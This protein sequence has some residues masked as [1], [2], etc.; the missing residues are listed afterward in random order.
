MGEHYASLIDR[1]VRAKHSRNVSE[2]DRVTRWVKEAKPRPA[3]E[4]FWT[5]SRGNSTEPGVRKEYGWMAHPLETANGWWDSCMNRQGRETEK[6][7]MG[8]P[9]QCRRATSS[10]RER[11]SPWNGSGSMDD[12]LRLF[13]GTGKTPLPFRCPFRL[14][15]RIVSPSGLFLESTLRRFGEFSFR[16]EG[17]GSASRGR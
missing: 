3:T 5:K 11:V 8:V 13:G 14:T 16:G 15:E 12:L 9:G 6:K 4:R 2:K 1:P 10:S 17:I 7:R